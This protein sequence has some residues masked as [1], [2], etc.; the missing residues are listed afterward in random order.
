MPEILV[1]FDTHILLD[2]ITHSNQIY[3]KA[4]NVMIKNDNDKL[5]ISK[6]IIKQY[7]TIMHKNGFKITALLEILRYLEE[8]KKVKKISITEIKPVS[9]SGLQTNDRPFV[10]LA[11]D[12]AKYLVT[13]DP[14]L[15][16]KYTEFKRK[17]YFE[18]TY[19]E[20]YVENE[21]H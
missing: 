4:Y 15:I 10:E 1:V 20:N 9:I 17:C 12:R 6:R 2:A 7:K 18:V 16:K 5:L 13:N 19:A 14:Y 8:I 21:S 11:C 3:E